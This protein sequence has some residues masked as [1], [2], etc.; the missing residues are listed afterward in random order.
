[1]TLCACVRACVRACRACVRACVCVTVYAFRV[2]ACV[3][4]CVCDCLHI[5]AGIH[6]RSRVCHSEIR[7][8]VSW[9]FVSVRILYFDILKGV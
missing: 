1:M 9:E 5:H 4:A 7:H 3:R 8:V 6:D 2:R